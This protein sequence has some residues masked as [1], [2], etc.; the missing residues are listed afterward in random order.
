MNAVIPILTIR[1]DGHDRAVPAGTTL[2]ALVIALGHEPLAVTTAVNAEF[3]PRA[4]R[5]SRLLRSGDAVLFFQP[6]V[7][8]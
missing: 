5:D 6:I 2:A 4:A 7:G 1:L 8:G 3:V